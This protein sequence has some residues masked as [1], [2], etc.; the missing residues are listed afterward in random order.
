[1]ISNTDSTLLIYFA[2]HIRVKVYTVTSPEN[3]SRLRIPNACNIEALSP[4]RTSLA[5]FL[6]AV[7]H[8]NPK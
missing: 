6:P 7:L 3:I 1:M 4:R 5:I 2:G 8:L